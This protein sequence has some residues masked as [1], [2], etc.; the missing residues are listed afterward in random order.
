VKA[1][2]PTAANIRVLAMAISFGCLWVGTFDR[3]LVFNAFTLRPI[4]ELPGHEHIRAFCN[5]VCNGVPMLAAGGISLTLW[6]PVALVC[7]QKVSTTSI[8]GS[9]AHINSLTAAGGVILATT[10]DH[11]V[12]AYRNQA[13]PEI[14]SAVH[15]EQ[16]RYPAHS[17]TADWAVMALHCGT[18]TVLKK[19]EEISEQRHENEDEAVSLI[20]QLTKSAEPHEASTPEINEKLFSHFTAAALAELVFGLLVIDAISATTT[21]PAECKPTMALSGGQVIA[22]PRIPP[23]SLGPP[24]AVFD[25]TRAIAMTL[26]AVHKRHLAVLTAS[27]SRALGE[28]V[29]RYVVQHLTKKCTNPA[30]CAAISQSSLK[31]IVEDALV[32]ESPEPTALAIAQEFP[33]VVTD[34]DLFQRT[35]IEAEHGEIF[36]DPLKCDCRLPPRIGSRDQ[37]RRRGFVKE[38][39]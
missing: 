4:I 17:G 31:H 32:Q 13:G 28:C 29:V 3:L 30:A 23:T 24:Q 37:A 8:S 9:F 34:A 12:L 22:L 33:M 10:L 6:D 38:L 35:K 1:E 14:V 16:F 20:V 36:T 7:I 21:L 19:L 27:S 2:E 26:A 18:S 11:V 39:P 5:V 15:P 25:S